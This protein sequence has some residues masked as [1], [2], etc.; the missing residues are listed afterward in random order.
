FSPSSCQLWRTA[1]VRRRRN[2]PRKQRHERGHVTPRSLVMPGRSSLRT[3]TRRSSL[4]GRRVLHQLFDHHRLR[5]C[6]SHRLETTCPTP[7][8]PDRSLLL[9]KFETIEA[10]LFHDHDYMSV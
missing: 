2:L 4:F 9:Y 1:M 8:H 10:Y 6:D 3:G 7:P 5:L